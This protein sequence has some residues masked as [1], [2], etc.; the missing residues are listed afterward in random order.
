MNEYIYPRSVDTPA[1]GGWT[2]V[3][4]AIV[5]GVV[6]Y[7]AGRNNNCGNWN[8]CGNGCGC[9]GGGGGQ[10]AFQQGEYTGENRAGINFIAQE[11]NKNN[12]AIV[13]LASEMNQSRIADLVAKNQALETQLL[14]KGATDG[15]ACQVAQVNRTLDAATTGAGFT[16]YPGCKK[17]CF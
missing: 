16:S 3:I 6:G 9:G 7:F 10:T 17:G 1:G 5:G 11:V 12:N 15:I 2:T 14:I 4:S 13:A 8:N